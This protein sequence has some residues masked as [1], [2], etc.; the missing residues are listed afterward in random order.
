MRRALITFA[1][2]TLAAVPAWPESTTR[3]VSLDGPW[4]FVTDSQ[5]QGETQR[6]YGESPEYRWDVVTVPHCWPV[7][8]RFPYTGPAWY[9]RHF[10]T[11][12][13]WTGLQV[14]LRFNAIF[15][16][17]R[18]WLNSKPAGS[19]EGGYTPFDLDVT[20]LLK[21]AGED[22]LL[23]VE[24]DNSWDTTTLP[25]ARPGTSPEKQLYPWWDFGGIVRDVDLIASAPVYPIRQ[26]IE[27][28]PDLHSG[29]ATVK[30]RVWLYNAAREFAEREVTLAVTR[31][32]K[33][34]NLSNGVAREKLRV[35]PLSEASVAHEFQLAKNDVALWSPDSPVLYELRTTLAHDEL[36]STFGIRRFEIRGT[37]LLLNGEPI[38]MGGANRP[39]DDP[40]YGLI[41]PV[42][43]IDRDMSLMKEAGL[44]MGRQI[45]YAQ[46]PA[47]LDWADHHGALLICENG[48]WQLEPEQMD[49]ALIRANW[50]SQMK[51]MIQRDWNHPSVIAWSVGNEFAS[52]S[53]AG[54]RWVRDGRDFVRTL[55][56]SRPVTFASNHATAA[57]NQLPTDEASGEVDLVMVNTYSDPNKVGAELDHVHVL[58][59]DK[60][61]LIS[62]Y[63]IRADGVNVSGVPVDG[64]ALA[65]QEKYFREFFAVLRA[66][67]WVSGA[68]IWTFNDYRS[69]FP[70]TNVDGYRWWGLVNAAR[71]KR[72]A[73]TWVRNEL[74]VAVLREARRAA[75]SVTLALSTRPDFPS[76]T[77]RG[78]S[79]RWTWLNAAGATLQVENEPLPDLAPG[80]SRQ[81]TREVPAKATRVRVDVVRPTGFSMVDRSYSVEARP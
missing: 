48:N 42:A 6:Y 74:S 4:L 56:T 58:W 50:Q 18:V 57:S 19:H 70:G 41:E 2:A 81:L 73:Y 72:P 51:E 16:K 63:G 71:E 36:K 68:S 13:D 52:N 31:E 44:E 49:S 22:N 5:H 23:V 59:P 75:G 39:A 40:R 15:Y 78:Y 35:P 46:S 55:D 27:A 37:Q 21:P 77:L 25:G 80:A 12:V 79:A 14:R 43:V 62:E 26:K 10:A 67:P 66:R 11:P 7:D 8:P 24:A 54:L 1:L 60:P 9:R 30:V 38:R 69:R 3:S 65:R 20:A 76:Y 53:P 47:L 32:G 45:H 28:V 64:D 61:L 33:P 34:Q 17:S 29:T